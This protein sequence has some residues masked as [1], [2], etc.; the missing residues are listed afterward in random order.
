MSFDNRIFNVNGVEKKHLIHAIRLAF[1]INNDTSTAKSWKF[2]PK[3]G[4]IL[5]WYAED[6]THKF[7]V[8]VSPEA[9][10][11]I[12]FEWLDSEEARNMECKDWDADSDHDGHNGYG[13]RVYVE[14]WGHV[15]GSHCALCAVRPAH[16]WYGK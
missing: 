9:A 3:Y 7:P 15:G 2:D 10:A 14:D 5:Y 4:L 1:D 12:A 11:E 16:V 6:G 13:W 8:P